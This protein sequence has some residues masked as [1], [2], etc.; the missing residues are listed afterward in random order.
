M[1]THKNLLIS[2]LLV[3]LVVFSACE[4][5]YDKPFYYPLFGNVTFNSDEVEVKDKWSFEILKNDYAKD[6]VRAYYRGVEIAGSDGKTF[7]ALGH[8]YAIDNQFIYVTRSRRTA[9]TLYTK[10]EAWIKQFKLE[11]TDQFVVFDSYFAKSNKQ[12]YYGF[13]N[14]LP[15]SDAASFE[16]LGSGFARDKNYGFYISKPIE[17][18]I[19]KSFRLIKYPYAADEKSVFIKNELIKGANSK[20]FKVL[21]YRV[22]KDDKN[23]YSNGEIIQGID[24]ASFRFI[25][26]S[27]YAKDTNNIYHKTNIIEKADRATF[28]VKEGS[29]YARDKNNY[30]FGAK[31]LESTDVFYSDAVKEYK[32]TENKL[33]NK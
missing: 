24:V 20:T 29:I 25:N 32:N 10:K 2:I 5:G 26:H 21:D 12:V 30:Y 17:N 31:I 19:G 7:K 1:I 13:G 18:S 15:E 8:G 6:K 3:I 33:Q 16:S 23:V 14:I 22:A 11:D 27:S 28:H 9:A 4:K